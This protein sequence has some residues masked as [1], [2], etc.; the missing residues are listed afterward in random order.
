M[1]RATR[2][3]SRL[4]GRDAERLRRATRRLGLWIGLCAAVIVVV[5]SA[6]AVLVVVQGQHREATAL[7]DQAITRADD[8]IDPPAGVWL[9]VRGPDGPASTPG[10]PAG[11]PNKAALDRTA[12]T[13]VATTVDYQTHGVE[14]RVQTAR[15][16]Q[17]TVQAALDLSANHAERTRLALALLLYGGFGLV[18]AAGTGMWLARR[19]VRPMANAL[20][21]QRQFVADASHEL[22]TPLTHLSTRVQLLHRHLTS[23]GTQENLLREADKV[24]A[25]AHH[26]AAILEDLLLAADQVTDVVTR[27]DL[28][29]LAD[30]VTESYR[31]SA[32]VSLTVRR[33]DAPVH[34]AGAPTAVRRAVTA[35]LD[36]AIRHAAS[37]VVITVN[38][39]DGNAV[40]DVADD[41]PGIDPEVLPRM[42]DRFATARSRPTPSPARRRYGLGLALVSDVAARHGG[43]VT[44]ETAAGGGARLR[45]S[46]PLDRSH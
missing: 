32:G 20:A 44:A 26:L 1:I 31:G 35:L 8:V 13:G 12:T 10:L 33:P 7:L 19:A 6:L 4:T 46:L 41:G 42:F 22:R 40:L 25:D 39:V 36:N 2:P 5:L 45:L 43:E 9:M 34:V 30:E 3:R 28:A 21:F 37:S 16:G 27:F 17:N 23:A 14:Y 29:A 38:A 18:L 24:V 11:L 15:R